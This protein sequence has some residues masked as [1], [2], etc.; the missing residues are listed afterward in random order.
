MS[1][2]CADAETL[3]GKIQLGTILIEEGAFRPESLQLE[4]APDAVGWQSVEPADRHKL[5][6]DIRH[7]ESI[8]F[9]IPHEISATA[10]GFNHQKVLR[11]ALQRIISSV[12]LQGCNCLQ[13]SNVEAKSFL[14]I[15]YVSLSAHPRHIQKCPLG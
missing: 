8:F 4:N 2:S 5:E 13:I 15:P 6:R 3:G 7:A 12:K 9:L 1:R 10:F 14:R 11:A